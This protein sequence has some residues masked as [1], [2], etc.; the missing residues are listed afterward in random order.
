MCVTPAA[1][2]PEA[3]LQHAAGR[4]GKGKQKSHSRKEWLRSDQQSETAIMPESNPGA[5]MY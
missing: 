4:I 1:Q 2:F 5:T 3:A